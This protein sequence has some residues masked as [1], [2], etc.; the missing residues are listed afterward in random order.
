MSR[1]NRGGYRRGNPR[2][3]LRLERRRRRDGILRTQHHVPGAHGRRAVRDGDRRGA[4]GTGIHGEQAGL[5]RSGGSWASDT[6]GRALLNLGRLSESAAIAEEALLDVPADRSALVLHSCGAGFH[7]RGMNSAAASHLEA[8]RTPGASSRGRQRSRLPWRSYGRRWRAPRGD[9]TMSVDRRHHRASGRG[10]T[11]VLG[12]V[13]GDLAARRDRARRDGQRRSRLRVRRATW[14]RSRVPAPRPETLLGFV[15]DVR[16][17][18]DAEAFGTPPA[19]RRR[20]SIAGHLARIEG[21]D[22]PALWVAAAE[23]FPPRSPRGLGARYRQAEAMLAARAPRDE[24]TEVM[25]VAHAVAVEI[26][27]GP[28]ASRFEAL[29]RRARIDSGSR[30]RSRRR[31]RRSPPRASHPR[32]AASPST[33]AG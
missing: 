2:P 10:D 7:R 8:A 11:H 21:R 27:A 12:H 33:S 18:R 32:R 31:T 30:L 4:G 13:R 17:Q 15:D 29:A 25:S 26:G 6:E 23:A 9:S 16:R 14:D 1:G 19:P 20:G 5:S 24:I 22:D 28:L 3:R